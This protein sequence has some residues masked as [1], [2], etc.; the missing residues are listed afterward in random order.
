MVIILCN[1]DE[2]NIPPQSPPN[3]PSGRGVK[4]ETDPFD[5]Q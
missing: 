2:E 3:P 1:K 4:G 5:V